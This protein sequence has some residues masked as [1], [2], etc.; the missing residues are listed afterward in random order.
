MKLNFHDEGFDKKMLTKFM[1]AVN[2]PDEIISIYI[3]SSGGTVAVMEAMLH[4][5][6]LDPKRF[7]IV[8]YSEL[9]SC[10]FEFYIRAQCK[11]Y[12]IPGTIGMYHQTCTDICLND[13][14]KPQYYD[15]EAYLKRK[16][17]FFY[18]EMIKFMDQCEMTSKE[19]K[20]IKNGDD[21]YFQYDRF[22]EIEKAYTKNAEL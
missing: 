7:N 22:L 6:S 14:G 20:R 12:L 11:K 18:P 16:K 15:G 4:V 9:D 17:K 2:Q 10:G 5:I 21:V 19:I 1:E 13:K 3:L 8:G